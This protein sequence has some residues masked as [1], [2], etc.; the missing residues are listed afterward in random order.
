M[1]GLWVIPAEWVQ[2]DAILP[3][4][5]Q[6]QLRRQG[7]GHVVQETG[8]G[9]I[10]DI[11]AVLLRQLRR[12]VPAAQHMGHPLGVQQPDHLSLQ[13]LHG[14]RP[15]V[16]SHPVKAKG[17]NPL[18]DGRGQH[19]AHR[20]EGQHPA[21]IGGRHGKRLVF[22]KLHL[23]IQLFPDVLSLGL[24]LLLQLRLLPLPQHHHQGGIAADCFRLPPLGEG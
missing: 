7:L 2:R 24:Q 8:P 21:H 3:A 13:K 11:G 5:L 14:K 17:T 1:E 12:R 18:Q 22:Q 6:L 20:L 9:G 19:I 23:S 4:Q 15:Q 10:G 16:P